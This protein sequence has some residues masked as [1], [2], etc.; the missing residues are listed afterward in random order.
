VEANYRGRGKYYPGKIKVD[1]GDGTYDIAYDDGESETRVKE[2][3]IRSLETKG[4]DRDRSPG[5]GSPSRS[6]RS[7]LTEGD[8]V[9]AN[10][11]GR[12]KYYPGKIKVDRGDGTY[13]IAYDD[14]ESE[15]RVKEGDIR[16]LAGGGPDVVKGGGVSFAMS[17]SSPVVRKTLSTERKSFGTPAVRPSG[18]SRFRRPL[19][20]DDA[21]S[22]PK[23]ADDGGVVSRARGG[24]ALVI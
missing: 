22:R 5:R 7:N 18:A 4:A 23:A 21:F 15:T 9:E 16:L 24:V 8:R 1:R 14:G 6:I 11:R 10:Y 13:D 12:G 19:S 17:D 20:K 2:G 3:D